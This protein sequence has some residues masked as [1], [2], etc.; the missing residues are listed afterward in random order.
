MFPEE[1][2]ENLFITLHGSWNRSQKVGYK[3][4][5]VIFDEAGDVEASED[6]INGWLNSDID[7]SGNIVETVFGR[8][9]APFIRSD[10]SM[11]ISDDK[12]NLIYRV[13]LK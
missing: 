10:G 3:L 5:R 1:F 12:A 2:Q 7:E 6:F 8:P 9:S 13:F 4:I 11:L